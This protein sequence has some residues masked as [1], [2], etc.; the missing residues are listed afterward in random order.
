LSTDAVSYITHTY[1]YDMRLYTYSSALPF[2][3]SRLPVLYGM[4]PESTV[5]I[6]LL[7]CRLFQILLRRQDVYRM[8]KLDE[9]YRNFLKIMGSS[10]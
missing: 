9:N 6:V 5:P 7:T 4:K 8:V 3:A 10:C 2:T 1:A